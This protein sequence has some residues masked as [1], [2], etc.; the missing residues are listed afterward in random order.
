MVFHKHANL[1]VLYCPQGNSWKLTDF[2]ICSEATSKKGRPTMHSRG[3]SSYRAP[4]L[5]VDEATFTNRVD[6]WTAYYMS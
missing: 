4:E 6:I 1:L 5:L 3:T 2:G